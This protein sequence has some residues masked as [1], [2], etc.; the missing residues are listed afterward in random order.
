MGRRTDDM[1]LNGKIIK[2][3]EHSYG[4]VFPGDLK[5]YLLV[6]YG[7]EPFPY[8]F[9]E[10]DLYENMRRDICNYE[11]G[12]LDVTVKTRSEYLREELEHLKGLYIERLDEIRD[13]RDYITELEHKL[14][15]HG[16]ESPRM[17]DERLKTRSFEI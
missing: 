6:K 2:K 13:L 4:K 8:E 7:E 14:S 11:A 3:I 12:E 15:E 10:Q 17:A 5:K 16:L 9:T 1:I